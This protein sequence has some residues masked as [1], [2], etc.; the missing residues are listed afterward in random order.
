MD[1]SSLCG[2]GTP[3][4]KNKHEIGI[5]LGLHLGSQQSTALHALEGPAEDELKVSSKHMKKEH[6]YPWK[7]QLEYNPGTSTKSDHRE[8]KWLK[9]GILKWLKS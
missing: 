1:T 4:P 8:Q 5:R 9:M 3:K 6:P 7:A 2:I